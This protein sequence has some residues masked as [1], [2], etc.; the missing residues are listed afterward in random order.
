MYAQRIKQLSFDFWLKWTACAVT[1][2]AAICTSLGYDPLNVYA[3][4]VGA[5][6]YLTWS[7]RIREWNLVVINGGL[8]IIYL[9]GAIIRITQ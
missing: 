1:L 7:Y 8:L 5:I 3:F 9:I 2:V 6:L 4:I